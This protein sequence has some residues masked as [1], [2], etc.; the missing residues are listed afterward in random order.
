MLNKGQIGSHLEA[1][2][3]ANS[4]EVYQ[5]DEHVNYKW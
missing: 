4:I 1:L 5:D 2:F 3:C